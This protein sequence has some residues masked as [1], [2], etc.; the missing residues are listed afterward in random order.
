[1]GETFIELK[2]P[3]SQSS[4]TNPKANSEVNVRPSLHANPNPNHREAHLRHRHLHLWHPPLHPPSQANLC[5]NSNPSPPTAA[6]NY[7]AHYKHPQSW[8]M[9]WKPC[10]TD[11]DRHHIECGGRPP[12]PPRIVCCQP[13][14][15][16]LV[17]QD[18]RPRSQI[19]GGCGGWH[20]ISI[21]PG[22]KWVVYWWKIKAPVGKWVV[23]WQLVV[24][25]YDGKWV[26]SW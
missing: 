21:A 3:L 15:V 12:P 24:L 19:L 16:T 1:M 18:H 25:F 5:F 20:R 22:G 17:G 8:D 6:S 26:V 10:L 4:R 11:F 7:V 23:S 2:S 14:D 13:W 9:I